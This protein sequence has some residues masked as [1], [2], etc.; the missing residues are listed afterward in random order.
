MARAVT[1]T[2]ALF[3]SLLIASASSGTRLAATAECHMSQLAVTAGPYISEAAEQHTLALRLVNY[4]KQVC[5][6]DGYPRL[7]LYDT[8]GMIPFRIRVGGDQ[9]I[10][11]RSPK[12]VR[13]QPGA[14]AFLLLNKNTCVNGF[15]RGATMLKIATP[16]AP[17][18]GV[19]SFRFPPNM[20]YPWR[21]PD[22]CAKAIDPGSVITVS[23]FVPTV[24]AALKR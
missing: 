15:S 3:V 24:R 13:L 19:A 20:P 16:S 4:G 6:L 22:S 9:M 14:A 10:S 18:T 1:L 7:T 21:I 11:T 5:V 2:S 23:P 12:L 17:G 8:R